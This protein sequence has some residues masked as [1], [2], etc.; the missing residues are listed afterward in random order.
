MV[1]TAQLH[2]VELSVVRAVQWAIQKFST[3]GRW[4]CGV[5]VHFMTEGLYAWSF[6][7]SLRTSPEFTDP[8]LALVDCLCDVMQEI[9]NAS[10]MCRTSNVTLLVC[11][12]KYPDL[13][14]NPALGQARS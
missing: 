5:V 4:E 13:P 1:L 8:D 6:R 3:S 9:P 2:E 10:A 11:A 14:W 7:Q 12:L